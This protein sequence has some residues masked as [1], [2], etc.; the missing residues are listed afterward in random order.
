MEQLSAQVDIIDFE[1]ELSEFEEYRQ[2]AETEGFKVDDDQKADWAMR[3]LASIRKRQE[4]NKAIHK[5]D[6]DRINT[7][8]QKVNGSLDSNALYFEAVL[9]EYAF[10]QRRDGRKSVVLPHGTVKTLAGRVHIDIQEPEFIKWA[11]KNAPDLI[12]IKTEISKTEL[13]KLVK[14]DLQVVTSDGEVVPFVNAVMGLP[15]ATFTIAK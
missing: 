2:Q 3:H 5:A 9:A 6:L 10:Q 13:N 4:V 7:W 14:D 8:L 1:P 15:S 11:T 12:R